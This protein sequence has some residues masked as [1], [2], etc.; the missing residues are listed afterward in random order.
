MDTDQIRLVKE[1]VDFLEAETIL[2]PQE[3][4]KK[5][6]A[7]IYGT[8]ASGVDLYLSSHWYKDYTYCATSIYEKKLYLESQNVVAYFAFPQLRIAIP[9]R[10]GNSIL[11]NPKEPH[12]I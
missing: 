2:V 11:F 6:N 7:T 10:P 3:S 12:C 1:A 4:A 9:L 5:A 8:Y